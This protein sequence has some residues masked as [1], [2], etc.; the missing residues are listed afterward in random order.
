MTPASRQLANL[1]PR[2]TGADWLRLFI[3]A[4]PPGLSGAARHLHREDSLFDPLTKD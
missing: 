1:L 4:S 2:Q 3:A